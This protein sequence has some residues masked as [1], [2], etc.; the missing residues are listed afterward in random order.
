MNVDPKRTGVRAVEGRWEEPPL[1]LIDGRWHG[2]PGY[3]VRTQDPNRAFAGFII[4][5]PGCGQMGSA[6]EGAKWSCVGG[7]MDDVTGLSLSPS[8]LKN[9]CGWHGY[10]RAGMFESC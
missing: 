8:I 2:P 4:A 5:C 7:S 9:C 3:M 1:E 10:L 6:R